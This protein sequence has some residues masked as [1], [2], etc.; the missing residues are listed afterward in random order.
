[1]AVSQRC[2]ER[3]T[4]AVP[5]KTNVLT[6]VH[7]FGTEKMELRNSDDPVTTILVGKYQTLIVP[8]HNINKMS[9]MNPQSES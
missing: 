5:I 2:T 8:M 7:L 1:M 9:M 4:H 6:T 3:Q